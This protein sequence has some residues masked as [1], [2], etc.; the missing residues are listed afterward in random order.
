[1]FLL[2]GHSL[3]D[4]TPS[5][6][7]ERIQDVHVLRADIEAEH[8]HIGGNA[9]GVIGFGQRYPALLQRKADQDLLRGVVVLLGDLDESRVIG[10]VIAYYGRV[11]FDDDAVLLAVCVDNALLTP[12]VELYRKAHE[13]V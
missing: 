12:R 2:V 3:H 6:L 9:I 4:G 5:A 7:I 1:M 13:L 11:S 8:V 10:F